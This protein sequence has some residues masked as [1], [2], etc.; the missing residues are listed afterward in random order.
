M[1]TAIVIGNPRLHSRTAQAATMLATA[2]TG[3]PPG[4]TIELAELGPAL[5]GWNDP[6][7]EAAVSTVAASRLVIVASPTFKASYSGLL[8][9]FLDQFAGGTGL[10]GVVAI[11]LMLGATAMHGMAAECL[12][13]PV[14]V[15]LGAV[16]P[17]PGLFLLEKAFEDG[18]AIQSYANRWGPA[19]RICAGLHASGATTESNLTC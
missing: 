7:V 10:Q 17:A 15:H 18:L 19:A 2:L 3:A 1:K 9:L 5:L 6:A 11:P 8:K 13:K 4:T 14:L 16:C 12:L